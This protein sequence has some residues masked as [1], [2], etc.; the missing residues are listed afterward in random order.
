MILLAGTLGISFAAIFIRAAQPAPP[1]VIAFYRVFFAGLMMATWFAIR[2]RKI[3][4]DAPGRNAALLGGFFFATDMALW[5]TALVQT[6]VANATLL[7]NTTPLYIGLFSAAVFG[8][9]LG[10][11]FVIG[12]ALALVGAA[13]L[14]GVDGLGGEGIEGDAIALVAALFYAGYLLLM[15]QARRE[16]DAAHAV[17]A[18]SAS[19]TIVLGIS[20]LARGDPFAGFPT[21]SWLAM[22]GAALVSQIGGVLGIAWALGYLRA[23]YASVALLAQPLGT[24][25]LGWLLLGEAITPLQ[26]L[27][28]M[29][30]IAGIAVVTRAPAP[31]G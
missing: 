29:G 22:L 17:L 19:A 31:K 11:H 8:E 27:G 28:G 23:T 16:L 20:A 10:R 21:T 25:L 3:A 9:H 1:V 24:A 26:A 7:V 6:S 5:H 14:L 30:V 15:K 12:A 2:G 13:I 4:F 18:A